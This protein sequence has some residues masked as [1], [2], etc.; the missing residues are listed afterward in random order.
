MPP[1]SWW[2][3]ELRNYIREVAYEYHVRVFG[4]QLARINFLPLEERLAEY[5]AM[6]DRAWKHGMRRS[7]EE[8]ALD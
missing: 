7:P 3:P 2:T 6:R 5:H 1:E 8:E 4:E